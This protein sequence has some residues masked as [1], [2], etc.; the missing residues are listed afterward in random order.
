MNNNIL[1]IYGFWISPKG[2]IHTII[3]DFGHK[4]FMEKQLGF[5][6]SDENDCSLFDDGWIRIVNGNQSFMVNYRCITSMIQ[7]K[8]ISKIEQRLKKDGYNHTSFILDYG[9]DYHIFN[10]FTEM[11]QR[12]KDRL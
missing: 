5:Q 4:E 10:T 11:M 9:Y 8:A 12:I 1:N 6:I 2:E 7:L 3:N